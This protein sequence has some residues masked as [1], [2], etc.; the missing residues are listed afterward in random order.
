M[1]ERPQT[2][3]MSAWTRA[4][5]AALAALCAVTLSSHVYTGFEAVRVKAVRDP[6]TFNGPDLSVTMPET[7]RWSRMAPPLVVIARLQNPSKVPTNILATLN[8]K[9]LD[10][11]LPVEGERRLD[12]VVPNDT[13]IRA[14]DLLTF[15]VE[16]PQAVTDGCCTLES[17][18][19]ANVHGGSTWIPSFIIVPRG[20]HASTAPGW[21]TVA[22]ATLL[23]AWLLM[24]GADVRHTRSVERMRTTL[25]AVSVVLFGVAVLSTAI[26]FTIVLSWKSFVLGAVALTWPG[27]VRTSQQL[28][29]AIDRLWPWAPSA[30]QAT[31]VACV[32]ALFYGLFAQT[33]LAGYGG[34]YSGFLKIGERYADRAPFLSE[35]P[36]LK[37]QLQILPGGGYDGQFF[38]FIAFDPFLRAFKD[39]PS[40]YRDFVDT[41]P[42]RYGRIG[43]SLL[44]TLCSWN[45]PE[46]YPRTM[47]WLIV[48]GSF[49]GVWWLACIAQHRGYSAWWALLYVA[50]PGFI[51]S[52]GV[53]TPEGIAAACLLGGYLFFLRARYGLAG[54]L[55]AASLLVRETGIVLVVSLAVW[56]AWRQRDRYGGLILAS[57]ILPLVC[58]RLYIAWRLFADFG[59]QGLVYNP[60]AFGTPFQGFVEL[61]QHVQVG[62]FAQAPDQ[63]WAGAY[64]SLLL[65]AALMVAAYLLWK[66]PSGLTA[67]TAVY[68]LMGVSL[69]YSAV[70]LSLN[71]AERTTYEVFLLLIVIFV[72]IDR[73]M[74]PSRWLLG[75][76]MVC[77]GFYQWFES[78]DAPLVRYVVLSSL[79]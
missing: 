33:Q 39:A 51:Q 31:L 7:P 58:W 25:A 4:Y 47:I 35:R 48:T 63:A 66:R 22:L 15:H 42:Y 2:A 28:R 74:R 67:A 71:N 9:R 3:R 32:V 44:T 61:W 24:R 19:I 60:Q 56:T 29:R 26:A 52:L 1:N 12:L 78:V 54:L 20:S 10:L 18:E 16:T 79:R 69:T 36:D 57:A 14:G 27:I 30:L 17:L 43:F 64:F 53:G 72:S 5:V 21:I 49:A 70:L 13:R 41:P 45:A 23:I 37:A 76:L 59:W 46:Q 8:G 40:R 55:F 38:Y 75:S 34:N 11:S 65:V 6:R 68:A 50:V 73:T 62:S 77:A